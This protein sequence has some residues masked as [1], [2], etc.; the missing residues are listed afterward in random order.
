MSEFYQLTP[1]LKHSANSHP[2][3]NIRVINYE[4]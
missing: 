4:E 3:T 2:R 1:A